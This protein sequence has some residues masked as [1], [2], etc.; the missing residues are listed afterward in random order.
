M[1]YHRTWEISEKLIRNT[2]YVK[3]EQIIFKINYMS[4]DFWRWKYL[5]SS[6]KNLFEFYNN[7]Y[8]A[9]IDLS[10]NFNDLIVLSTRDDETVPFENWKEL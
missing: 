4:L 1:I 8:S 7:L 3:I 2:S 6:R 5:D 10:S 9:S